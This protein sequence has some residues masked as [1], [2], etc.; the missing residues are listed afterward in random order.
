[1]KENRKKIGLSSF[2]F[3][4]ILSLFLVSGCADF[5]EEA[6]IEIRLT[7]EPHK[8]RSKTVCS[9]TVLRALTG[10]M[11][12]IVLIKM[13]NMMRLVYMEED[14]TCHN[15]YRNPSSLLGMYLF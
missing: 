12:C 15:L 3:C 5:H 8:N 10:I 2:N 4:S 9:K 14:T 13:I 1:M 11:S 7:E 6:V